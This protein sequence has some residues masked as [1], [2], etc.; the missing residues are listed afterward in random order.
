MCHTVNE[1]MGEDIIIK[2]R[3]RKIIMIKAYQCGF[4]S[5]QSKQTR[6]SCSECSGETLMSKELQIVFVDFEKAHGPVLRELY[7]EKVMGL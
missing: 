1:F 2:I 4:R 6:Y 7:L 3:S 5:W